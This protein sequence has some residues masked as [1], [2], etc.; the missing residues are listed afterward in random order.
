MST[1]AADPKL[2]PAMQ[3]VLAEG[4]RPAPARPATASF[5]FGWR[6]V[7]KIKH[8]PM[9]LFDVTMFPIM[10]LLLFTYM[11]GGALAGSTSEYLQELLPGILVMTVAMITP[12]TGMNLNTD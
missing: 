9:Q 6:A 3:R 10:F 5:V 4:K 2:A 1:T 7:L 11:F 12:Y 8:I